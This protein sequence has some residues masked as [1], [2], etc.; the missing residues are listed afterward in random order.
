MVRFS[1]RAPYSALVPFFSRNWRDLERHVEREAA[2]A[3]PRVDVVL[4]VHDVL[5]QNRGQRFGGQRLVGD[6]AIDAVDELGREA[7]AH[8]AQPDALQFA[9]QVGPFGGP[10]RLEPEL[11]IDLLHHFARAQVAGEKHQ[12]LFE[13]DRGVVAQPQEAFIQHAQQQARHRGRGLFDFVEQHQREAALFAGHRI[14]L[15]LRQH[16]L[17]FAVAQVSGRRADQFG[18]L[19]LHLELAAIHLENV[20]LAAVQHVGQ[21]FDGLGLAGTSRSQQQEHTHRAAFRRQA[22]LEHLNVRDNHPRG[23]GLADDF[24]R[25]YRGQVFQRAGWLLARPARL[26]LGLFHVTLR[27]EY[28]GGEFLDPGART[29]SRALRLF[30]KMTSLPMQ[31]SNLP[32]NARISKLFLI[33]SN[34]RV[35]EIHTICLVARGTNCVWTGSYQN[36]I[37]CGIFGW[38]R[39]RTNCYLCRKVIRPF[40]KS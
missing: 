19:V 38:E 22:G 12:A 40:V 2:V 25:Q 10:H 14:Q 28:S 1:S 13:I 16:R 9:G 6:D 30:H 29:L 3:E 8:R 26:A 17:G 31:F 35:T 36:G 24:L 5:V 7:L 15:L 34:V 20:L 39:H 21:R 11:R 27:L 32:G 37:G 33:N 4:Q 18:D 23:G